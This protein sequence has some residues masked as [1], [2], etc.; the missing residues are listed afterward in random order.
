MDRDDLIGEAIIRLDTFDFHLSPVHTAWYTLNAEVGIS[1]SGKNKI[2][3][4]LIKTEMN[5][6]QIEYV[7][8]LGWEIRGSQLLSKKKKTNLKF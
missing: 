5:E 7:R 2:H 3:C 6:Q 8:I 1:S 4:Y